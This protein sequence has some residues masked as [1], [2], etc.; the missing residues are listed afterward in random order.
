MVHESSVKI[1]RHNH[2]FTDDLLAS[3]N[4]FI[5]NGYQYYINKPYEK[6]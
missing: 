5:Y 4:N 1:N 2:C 3:G 6:L